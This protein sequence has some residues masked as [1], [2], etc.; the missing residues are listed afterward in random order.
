MLEHILSYDNCDVDLQNRLDG[1][2]PLLSV[3]KSLKLESDI[4]N[5]IVES[6]LEAGA[7]TK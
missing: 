3:I 2:T 4:R 1:D 7:D 6:L 5:T